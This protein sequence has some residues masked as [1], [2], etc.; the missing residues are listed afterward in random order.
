MPR[1]NEAASW[2]VLAYRVPGE[3]A[4]LRMSVWRRLKAA[5]AVYLVNSVAALPAAPA[6][7][8]SS[9]AAQRHEP[10][11]RIGPLLRAGPLAGGLDL[12]QLYNAARDDEYAQI[13]AGCARAAGDD[14][15]VGG[16]GDHPG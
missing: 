4:R 12:V 14:R 3:A 9:A 1:V 15:V 5:G 8:R 16:E 2:L 7:E 10:G 6:A 13:I 11:R